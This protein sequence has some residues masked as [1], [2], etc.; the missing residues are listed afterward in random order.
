MWLSKLCVCMT[1]CLH[2]CRFVTTEN[3]TEFIP[4]E[5][6]LKKF[7]GENSWEYD[8]DVE[9]APMMVE[10]EPVWTEEWYASGLPSD[11]VDGEGGGGN[12]GKKQVRETRLTAIASPPPT[13]GI[14]G[15]KEVI[16]IGKRGL[17]G[18]VWS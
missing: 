9:R 3:I 18:V 17:I 14:C 13:H 1:V 2:C 10:M 7:G 6:L 4:P 8:F 16:F 11:L 15:A 12:G 5:V